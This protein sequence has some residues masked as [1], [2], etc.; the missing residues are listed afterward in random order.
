[1][2]SKRKIKRATGLS[3][4][5]NQIEVGRNERCPCNSGMKYKYCHGKPKKP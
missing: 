4:K 2:N 5:V 1:M 3:P